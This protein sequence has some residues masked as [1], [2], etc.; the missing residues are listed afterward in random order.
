MT[1]FFFAINKHTNS[2]KETLEHLCDKLIGKDERAKTAA[3]SNYTQ[4]ESK[5]EIGKIVSLDRLRNAMKE[6]KSTKTPG[7]Y[8][9]YQ[10]CQIHSKEV[11][12]RTPDKI[13]TR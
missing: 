13:R 6:L 12:P 9:T 3:D 5:C 10:W 2:Q 4:D 8:R 7:L 11:S 1:N